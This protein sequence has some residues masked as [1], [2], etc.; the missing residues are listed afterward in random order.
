MCSPSA[1]VAR[2]RLRRCTR[3]VGCGVPN[4][5]A[6]RSTAAGDRPGGPRLKLSAQPS[7]TRT[8]T[9]PIV[10]LTN[11][12][13]AL[14]QVEAGR[15]LRASSNCRN[16]RHPSASA[17]ASSAPPRASTAA[18]AERHR[19][20]ACCHRQSRDQH[21]RAHAPAHPHPVDVHR[22]RPGGVLP[23]PVVPPLDIA[24]EPADR[25]E[26][27]P[28]N[29]AARVESHAGATGHLSRL[30]RDRETHVLSST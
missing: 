18:S 27:H 30:P 3:S 21:D 20:S 6:A 25:V 29:L 28:P 12:Q 1:S 5:R 8:V 10:V 2:T 14:P 4:R 22:R 19:R 9:V 7:S 16:N 13:P 11:E 23:A 17:S 15:E 26:R 24:F